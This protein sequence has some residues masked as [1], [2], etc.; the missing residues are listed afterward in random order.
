MTTASGRDVREWGPE[1]APG[2]LGQQFQ[3]GLA[4]DPCPKKPIKIRK[5]VCFKEL[6]LEGGEPNK[7]QLVLDA[8]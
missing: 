3:T 1:L 7:P 8:D 5:N 2:S 4:P 6:V